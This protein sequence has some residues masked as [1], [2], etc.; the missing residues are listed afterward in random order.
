[1]C[2]RLFLC[3]HGVVAAVI[4][5]VFIYLGMKAVGFTYG[6]VGEN[7]RSTKSTIP[8]MFLKAFYWQ[9][10]M[11][12][13][14]SRLMISLSDKYHYILLV[15]CVITRHNEMINTYIILPSTTLFVRL[16]RNSISNAIGA[17][18]LYRLHILPGKCF[19]SV[20]QNFCIIFAQI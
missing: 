7:Y 6:T 1:M 19:L 12:I 4:L 8:M 17:G 3:G 13:E 11:T 16:Y 5:S 20:Q 18:V 9:D 14:R 2:G 10:I 15:D